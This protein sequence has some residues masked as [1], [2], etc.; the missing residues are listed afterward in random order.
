MS[1]MNGRVLLLREEVRRG[2]ELGTVEHLQRPASHNPATSCFGK[3][4]GI[5]MRHNFVQARGEAGS[6]R[7][8]RRGEERREAGWCRDRRREAG[9]C[10]A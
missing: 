8:K 3:G 1:P 7:E 6:C 5:L 9:S 10:R 2:R 4:V